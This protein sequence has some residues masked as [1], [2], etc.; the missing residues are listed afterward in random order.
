MCETTSPLVRGHVKTRRTRSHTDTFQRCIF[1]RQRSRCFLEY[2][3]SCC[4]CG[5]DICAVF[6]FLFISFSLSDSVGLTK[7]LRTRRMIR[8]CSELLVDM[9]IMGNYKRIVKESNFL[10]V[11]KKRSHWWRT[12]FFQ[13]ILPVLAKLLWNASSAFFF[14][15][16][17]VK[18]WGKCYCR[19][20]TIQIFLLF[21]DLGVRT[22][23]WRA[24]S[25]DVTVIPD[26]W[27]VQKKGHPN[28][29]VTSQNHVILNYSVS[30][31]SVHVLECE[32]GW[33]RILFFFC[34]PFSKV[35]L[36]AIFVPITYVFPTV[37]AVCA[38]ICSSK[39]SCLI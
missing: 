39:D 32:H 1:F 31:T 7:V 2:G 20:Q 23:S 26:G 8:S 18:L 12:P 5:P 25:S 37:P 24:V 15:V 29:S 6:F 4:I 28:L 17:S 9:L 30:K 21:D 36:K 10:L 16:F 11:K 22:L 3:W 34:F 13:Q 38:V 19:C 14:Q 27:S 35:N 33:C